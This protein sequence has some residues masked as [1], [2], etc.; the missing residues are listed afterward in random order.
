[1]SALD[2]TK[3]F[4]QDGRMAALNRKRLASFVIARRGELGYRDRRAFSKAVGISDRTIGKVELGQSVSM[5][6]LGVVENGLGWEPG[7]AQQVLEGGDPA[8]RGQQAPAGPPRRIYTDPV[9][10][11]AWDALED[12]D[13][14]DE[15]KRGM[16]AYARAA[17]EDPRR[18]G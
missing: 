12:V 4:R 9:M 16:I 11:E 13:L 15:V 14:P 18:V 7:S 3:T 6:T 17:R 2:P 5:S 8:I 1:V 10:Q